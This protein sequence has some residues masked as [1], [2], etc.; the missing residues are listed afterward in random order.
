MS[1][2][3]KCGHMCELLGKVWYAIRVLY[4]VRQSYHVCSNDS[5]NILLS[6]LST[7]H[8]HILDILFS[9]K[10]GGESLGTAI[11]LIRNVNYLRKLN[12]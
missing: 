12:T 7:Y 4:S 10:F 9:F 8:I 3:T 5:V 6:F 11:K 1:F 2:H